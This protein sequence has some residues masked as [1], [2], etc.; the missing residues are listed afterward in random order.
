MPR[1]APRLRTPDGKLNLI[2]QRVRQ[3]RTELLL[4][5]D[6]LCARLADVTGGGWIADRRDIFR[7]E[8]GRRSIHDLELVAL[9]QA[10]ECNI[11]WLLLG[12]PPEA[13]RN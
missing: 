7:I 2:A 11:L 5:Q 10:L 8:D 3:R 1:G 4:T 9:S 12:D 13:R 6:G